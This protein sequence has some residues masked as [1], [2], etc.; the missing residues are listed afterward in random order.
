MFEIV[1]YQKPPEP[2]N[3]EVLVNHTAYETRVAICENGVVQD[4]FIERQRK[5]GLVGNIYKGRVQRVLPGMDA[6]FIDIGLERAGFLHLKNVIGGAN[7][8]KITDVLR[9]GQN[10]IV[11]VV[12]DP[13]GNKGAYLSMEIA[14]PSRFLVFLP[15]EDD[16]G[17]SFKIAEE[18]QRQLLREMVSELHDGKKG[19]FIVRTAQETADRSIMRADM[20]YLEKI[21]SA[22]QIKG[23]TASVGTLIYADLPLYLRAMRDFISPRVSHVW[24]DDPTA[25]QVMKNFAHNFLD[26]SDS[27]LRLHEGNS[28]LFD[29]F[30][31]EEEIANSLKR[32]VSLKSG[33]YLIIDQTEAM[34][35][36]DVNTGGFVGKLS[37]EDTIFKTNLEAAK[38]IARQLRLRNLG[39]IILVDFIDMVEKEHQDSVMQALLSALESDRNKHTV[40]PMSPLGIIEMTR[41]RTRESLRQMMC[42]TCP[43]CEGKGYVKTIETRV[44]ELFRDLEREAREYQPKRMTVLGDE[45]LIDFIFEE[46]SLT[47]SDLQAQLGVVIRLQSDVGYRAG[48]YDIAVS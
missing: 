17:V 34:T 1:V 26:S 12:K 19:G 6:A 7:A 10:V 3:I 43:C 29:R 38:V 11:Q 21:W 22:I 42:E 45:Q 36:I 14:I 27:Q 47:F 5:R 18:S 32:H 2:R 33:G 40:S 44:Y 23:K 46:E 30:G 41:K 15:Y 31:V 28:S 13:I 8:S 48:E 4:V 35:T 37:Q 25:L 9:E 20:L 24:V 16:V 39:G